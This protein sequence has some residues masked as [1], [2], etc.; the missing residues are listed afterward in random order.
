M[1][2]FLRLDIDCRKQIGKWCEVSILNINV[3]KLVYTNKFVRIWSII[4]DGF[5]VNLVGLFIIGIKCF[6]ISNINSSA[7][8]YWGYDPIS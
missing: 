3:L 6:D 7:L 2:S 8:F 5:L 4:D 1:F